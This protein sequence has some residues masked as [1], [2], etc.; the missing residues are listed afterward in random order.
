MAEQTE[1]QS[2]QE[3][4]R[5]LKQQNSKTDK[6]E[7][8]TRNETRRA[9]GAR[10]AKTGSFTANNAQTQTG[11]AFNTTMNAAFKGLT[12][13]FEK[14]LN[15]PASQETLDA[16][17]A[18]RARLAES[19][20]K[21]NEELKN[22]SSSRPRDT[23]SGRFMSRQAATEKASG[24]KEALEKQTAQLKASPT[25]DTA[26][27]E[28]QRQ[29]RRDAVFNTLQKTS[30]GIQ[31][32]LGKIASITK[33][34]PVLKKLEESLLGAIT[35]GAAAF[36]AIKFLEGIK[37]AQD[38]FGDNPTFGQTIASGIAE[39]IGSLFGL[40]EE[41]KK[42]MAIGINDFFTTVGNFFKNLSEKFK[43]I[44]EADGILGKIGEFAKQFPILTAIIAAFVAL[45]LIRTLTAVFALGK[46]LKNF[47]FRSKKVKTDMTKMD[48]KPKNTGTQTQ[49]KPGRGRPFMKRYPAGTTIDGKKVGGQFYNAN[50]PPPKNLKLPGQGATNIVADAGKNIGKKVAKETTEKAAKSVAKSMLRKAAMGAAGLFVPGAGWI[51]TAAMIADLG[52]TAYD[53]AKNTEGGRSFL[54]KYILGD[55]TQ[56]KDPN[57]GPDAL[58]DAQK[59][60]LLKEQQRMQRGQTNQTNNIDN[61][62]TSKNETQVKIKPYES[63]NS[64]GEGPD[65]FSA[66]P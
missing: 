35:A 25:G 44:A 42:N 5:L 27:D 6:K 41:E 45:P 59:N 64:F 8:N 13:A 62:V 15:R 47:L 34:G 53:L 20:K 40:T 12:V 3:I 63:T 11:K 14:V 2:L 49:K 28:A 38:W 54:N 1:A 9:S 48:Q 30:L 37:K 17:K 43:K 65:G 58:S 39:V 57:A 56:I 26:G 19:I 22:L 29:K 55:K 7:V 36:G 33:I 4:V 50:K 32:S 21:L 18:E 60:Q 61:S 52:Y 31:K 24:I 10:P 16:Q 66:I 23:D 51:M 46:L